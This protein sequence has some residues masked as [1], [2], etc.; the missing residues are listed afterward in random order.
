VSREELGDSREGRL[1]ETCGVAEA[2]LA[3]LPE[4]NLKPHA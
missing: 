1:E 2:V 3:N 4:L